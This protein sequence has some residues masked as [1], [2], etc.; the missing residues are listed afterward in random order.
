MVGISRLDVGSNSELLRA[1]GLL[2]WT[3]ESSYRVESFYYIIKISTYLQQYLS[4]YL[5]SF[6]CMKDVTF[7]SERTLKGMSAWLNIHIVNCE[8]FCLH[9]YHC[10][11]F[12]C[13]TWLLRC[14]YC[15]LQSNLFL[16]YNISPSRFYRIFI[17]SPGINCPCI[18]MYFLKRKCLLFCRQWN[19]SSWEL[20]SLVIF[21]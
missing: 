10:F 8:L 17:K 21:Q 5:H 6:H 9:C 13:K 2:C 14:S 1:H 19:K 12:L 3:S 16:L 11:V 20:Q 18:V 7:L 15:K 4:I